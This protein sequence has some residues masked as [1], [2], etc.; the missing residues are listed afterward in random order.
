MNIFYEHLEI[1]IAAITFL[2]GVSSFLITR[3]DELAWKRT[4]FIIQQSQL[5]DSDE[6]MKEITLILYGKHD[7]KSVA[8]YLVLIGESTGTTK[9]NED[10]IMQFE[11]YLNF[12][13]RIAY[14]FL[15]LKT[16]KKKDMYAFGAYLRAVCSNQELKNYCLENG[17]DEIVIAYKEL[18]GDK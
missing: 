15:V 2:L 6:G 3:K 14:A 11:K 13:W 16:L 1:I 5:L 9:E 17:Y 18:R 12:L 8:D 7:K 10:Y 4:E